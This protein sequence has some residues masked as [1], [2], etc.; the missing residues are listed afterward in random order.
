MTDKLSVGS[1]KSMA[2]L[3]PG[4][5]SGSGSREQSPSA[6]IA[7]A[8]LDH[9]M[10]SLLASSSSE[11]GIFQN[12]DIAGV[13]E[14]PCSD[15]KNR[16][17]SDDMNNISSFHSAVDSQLEERRSD[18][19]AE[20]KG[21]NGGEKKRKKRVS[22]RERKISVSGKVAAAKVSFGDCSFR[23]VV[24]MPARLVGKCVE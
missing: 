3:A 14:I 6:L 23:V 13:E 11:E 24:V 20:G 8:N 1:G 12:D 7:G 21:I 5:R 15:E 2:S 19:L 22:H 9:S 4:E 16:K 18:R 10:E 17:V